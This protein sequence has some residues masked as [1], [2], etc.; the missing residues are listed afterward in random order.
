MEA[1]SARTVVE[2][3][4][5]IPPISG[6][7]HTVPAQEAATAFALFM[8]TRGGYAWSERVMR[9]ETPQEILELVNCLLASSA[10]TARDAVQQIGLHTLKTLTR[11]LQADG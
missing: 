11:A 10:R 6:G 7:E 5:D 9:S 4:W 3:I 2:A 8:R 1:V